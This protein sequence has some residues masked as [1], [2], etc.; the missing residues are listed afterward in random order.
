MPIGDPRDSLVMSI[1][2]TRN[3]FFYPFLT[4]KIDSYNMYMKKTRL[5]QEYQA[6]RL[7]QLL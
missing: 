4:L 5:F 6:Q 2:D 3:G 1:G 7:R